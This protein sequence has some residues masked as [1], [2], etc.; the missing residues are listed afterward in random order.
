MSSQEGVRDV[1]LV[2]VT[3]A[4]ASR[5]FGVNYTPLPLMAD[6]ATALVGA[7][8]RHPGYRQVTG[9]DAGMDGP[10]FED[11]LGTF[12]R[13]VQAFRLMEPLLEGLAAVP[14]T[15]NPVV[16]DGAWSAWH[17]ER[18]FQLG[19]ITEV[20]HQS[21]YA[22]F[23]EPT[24]DMGAVQQGYG[25][26]LATLGIGPGSRWAIATTNYD[27]I[28]EQAVEAVGGM[29]DTGSVQ[30]VVHHGTQPILR[31][32]QLSEGLP[33]YVPILHLHG[34]VGWVRQTDGEVAVVPASAQSPTYGVPV[35]MLPDLE[36]DYSA[37]AVVSALWGEFRTLLS[38]A[39]RV[40]VLGHS[41]HDE[42]LVL[43]LQGSGA[44][45]AVTMM[46]EDDP[47]KPE[48]TRIAGLLPGATIIP[49]RFG[50]QP[51]G[52]E[53]LQAWVGEYA[54]LRR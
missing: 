39:Q 50:P 43:A 47:D 51:Q 28:A 44:R 36:K 22:Q 16:G 38:R 11:R 53:R 37:D 4:G 33:R 20:I 27:T 12:L 3:G 19:K 1:E 8:N 46:P 52:T 24:I 49:Y 31:V 29:P 10:E 13:Q 48:E 35:V 6:W 9:L 17:N 18:S 26:L 40:L 42:A 21:L 34:R 2:L 7:L 14:S 15:Q 5:E 45:L 54:S 25:A 23:G 32:E 30:L 41:L